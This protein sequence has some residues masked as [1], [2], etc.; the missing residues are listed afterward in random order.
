MS[1][2]SKGVWQEEPDSS[3]IF[4]PASIIILFILLCCVIAIGFA[5]ASLQGTPL[6]FALFFGGCL[7]GF[8]CLYLLVK[9]RDLGVAHQLNFRVFT[10]SS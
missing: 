5:V 1:S 7:V 2:A 3:L 8:E 6:G 4:H 9:L 10:T